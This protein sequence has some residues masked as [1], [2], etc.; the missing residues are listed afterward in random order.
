MS[1]INPP[2][3]KVWDPLVR[4]FH[5]T[6]AL[7][8]VANLTVLRHAERLHI[9]V[10]YAMVTSLVI[11][12]VWGLIGSRHARFSDFVPGQQ[13]L[14]RY[15]EALIRRREPRYVGHNPAG[16][17]MMLTLMALIAVMGLTGWMMG[18][19]RYWG[20][21]WVEEVHETTANIILAA[22]C[23]HVTA[24]IVESLRHRENLPWSMITGK[25][26]AASGTDIDYANFADRG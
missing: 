23:L 2:M 7:G 12:L 1:T 11:R 4:I 24:A 26:R 13:R 3:T 21:G 8:V 16:A 15:L 6:I 18:T 17:V 25:K 20:V 9:Y 19:D 14:A 5:W 10:G 22:A